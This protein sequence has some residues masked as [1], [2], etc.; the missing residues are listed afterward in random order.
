M[1][2]KQPLLPD[3]GED[4]VPKTHVRYILVDG[5]CSC[6]VVW[7]DGEFKV[8]IFASMEHVKKFAAQHEGMLVIDHTQKETE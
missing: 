6:L 8:E 7:P 2:S 5:R 3:V 1:K 4:I